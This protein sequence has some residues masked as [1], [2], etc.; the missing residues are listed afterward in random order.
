MRDSRFVEGL[1][2]CPDCVDAA[3]GQC[4]FC[5]E[6]ALIDEQGVCRRCHDHLAQKFPDRLSSIIAEVE[7]FLEEAFGMGLLRRYT[8]QLVGHIPVPPYFTTAVIVRGDFCVMDGRPRIRLREDLREAEFMAVFAHEYTHAWQAENCPPQSRD[9]LEGFARW[10]QRKVL[11]ELYEDGESSALE[12]DTREDYGP[13]LRACLA[14]EKRLGE[15]GLIRQVRE[16]T[17]FPP[18]SAR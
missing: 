4:S 3:M 10:V 2:V 7:R 17:H 15:K 6:V 12:R 1:R 14:W 16:W 18:L 13:G 11:F 5:E 8:L 9:L